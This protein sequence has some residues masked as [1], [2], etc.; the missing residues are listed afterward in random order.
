MVNIVKVMVA[1]PKFIPESSLVVRLGIAS[2]KAMTTL[3]FLFGGL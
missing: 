2:T 3:R 1:N